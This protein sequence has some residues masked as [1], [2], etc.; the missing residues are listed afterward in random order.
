M[1]RRFREWLLVLDPVGSYEKRV[2]LGLKAPWPVMDC[3][4][5]RRRTEARPHGFKRTRKRTAG[6]TETPAVSL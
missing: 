2:R 3:P 5:C 1:V 6:R 4:H